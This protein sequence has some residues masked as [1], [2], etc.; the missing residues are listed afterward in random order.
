MRTNAVR[1]HQPQPSSPCRGWTLFVCLSDLISLKGPDSQ[2]SVRFPT[3]IESRLLWLG[4]GALTN[5]L[6]PTPHLNYLSP[7]PPPCTTRSH[8]HGQ[9]F[10]FRTHRSLQTSFLSKPC[11]CISTRSS[12][13]SSCISLSTRSLHLPSRTSSSPGYTQRSTHA[14]SSTGMYTLCRLCR[15][16]SSVA[17]HYGCLSWT[18]NGLRWTPRSASMVIQ[19][20]QA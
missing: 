20:H 5:S 13:L 11:R 15:A 19:V 3:S 4:H 14:P 8:C 12:S 10:W 18:R 17:W 7:L 2:T 9:S 1:Q 16:Q 6:L